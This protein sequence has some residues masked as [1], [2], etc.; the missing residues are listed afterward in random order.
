M[1]LEKPTTRITCPPPVLLTYF[2]APNELRSL[3]RHI[4]G[5]FYKVAVVR[6]GGPACWIGKLRAEHDPH[7]S[8]HFSD[9]DTPCFDT[10]F[11][12]CA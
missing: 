7:T 3:H 5:F 9:A 2:P 12:V 10:S 1:K 6:K 8:K 4:H 11:F